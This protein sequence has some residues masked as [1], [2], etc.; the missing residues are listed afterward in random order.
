ML[1]RKLF[2]YSHTGTVRT[3]VRTVDLAV[4]A[5]VSEFRRGV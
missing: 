2:R 3:A 1:L 4:Q 5:V